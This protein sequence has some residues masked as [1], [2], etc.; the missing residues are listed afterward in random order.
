MGWLAVAAA[1]LMVGACS[2]APR[3]SRTPNIL[4]NAATDPFRWAMEEPKTNRVDVLYVTDR[5]AQDDKSGNRGYGYTR[6]RSLAFGSSVIEIGRNLPWQSLIAQSTT[7]RRSLSLPLSVKSVKEA[8]RFPETPILMAKSD[9]GLHDDPEALRQ[10]EAAAD[11]L[12]REV[13]ERLTHTS[14]KEAYIF[15]HGYN[16]SF[17][18]AA[19]TMAEVWHFLGHQGV[20]IAYTWPAGVGGMRGYTYDRESGEF[21]NYHFKQFLKI[22]ASTP[23]LEKIHLIAHSR[24]TDVTTTALRELFLE[25][26]AAGNDPR[27]EFKIE[28]L[29]LAAPD[30]DFDVVTQRVTA[31]KVQKDIGRI[32]VYVSEYDR[33]LGMSDWFFMGIRRL[34]QLRHTDLTD[35]MRK[36]MNTTENVDV[37]NVTAKTDF[38]GHAYFHTNPYVSADLVL[39][40][41]D[42][43]D[44]GASNGRPLKELAPHFWELATGYPER[45]K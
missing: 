2:S 45:K 13:V 29:V 20:P 37:I 21:T 1:M 31:E 33:A 14:R 23:G 27:K 44:A 43:L 41:R 18:D 32:T 4:V 15:V 6:S 38:I 34:G 3:L 8:G 30:M 7:L 17:S 10:Q 40:L 12:R 16:N 28:N 26:R 9:K 42:D 24:G 39:V 25:A 35:Q 36:N 11:A 19:F 5:N 22:L